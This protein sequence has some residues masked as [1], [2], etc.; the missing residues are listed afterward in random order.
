MKN[1]IK[2]LSLAVIIIISAVLFI[3]CSGSNKEKMKKISGKWM[4]E[5]TGQVC[6]YTEDGYFYEYANENFTY[7]KTHYS[8]DGNEI[9]Y[10]INGESEAEYSVE[11]ELKDGKLIIAGQIEYTRLLDEKM[12]ELLE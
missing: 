5:Q 4:D 10:Y 2:P 7:D 9:S 11:Y 6:E 1:L 12:L 8:I 3:S